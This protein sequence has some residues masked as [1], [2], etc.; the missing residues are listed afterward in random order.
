MILGDIL[1]IWRAS[2]IWYNRKIVILLPLFWWGL[3]IRTSHQ[4]NRCIVSLKYITVNMIIHS[5]F[6]HSGVSSTN[7]AVVCKATDIL[8]PVLSIMVNVSVMFLTIWKAWYV[9]D[10]LVGSACFQFN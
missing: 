1:V 2:A 7:Y 5:R 3:M 6:C 9:I 4:S 10:T 8:A